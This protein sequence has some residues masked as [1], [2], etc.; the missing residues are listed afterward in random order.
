MNQAFSL[1]IQSFLSFSFLKD[2]KNIVLADAG[3]SESKIETSS[4]DS[5]AMLQSLLT[6]L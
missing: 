2:S 5:N 6:L 1:S 4:S 3:G